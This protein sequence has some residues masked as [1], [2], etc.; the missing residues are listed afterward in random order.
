MKDIRLIA[1]DIDGTLFDPAG[2]LT[3]RT[4]RA[5]AACEARGIPVVLSSGRTF[6]GI[7]LIAKHAGLNSPIISSNGGRVDGSPFGPVLME[8][9]LPP[10]LAAPV[11]R[12]LADSG[13]YIEC[14]AGDTI[15]QARAELS[16][17]LTDPAGYQETPAIVDDDGYTQR[18][19]NDLGRMEREG[20]D[21]AYKF[22]AFSRDRSRLDA[23]CE[24]LSGLPLTINSAFLFNIE[25]M[26]RGRGKGRALRFL[27]E[28]YGL[29]MDQVMAFGD[30][31]NDLEMLRAAGV[32]VAMGNAAESLKREADL[33]APTNAEDGE[34]QI[35][36]QYVL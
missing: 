31:T 10:Q 27:A 11:F 16:P 2:H 8:D 7:R 25:I 1:T 22:A 9:V 20:R 29:E 18:F 35:I 33:V 30:G 26:E 19:V 14:Y 6:E 36:E 17:F 21:R 34:A 5:I 24:A 3:G 23:I 13:L 4:R 15:Y 32:G 12:V 28:H